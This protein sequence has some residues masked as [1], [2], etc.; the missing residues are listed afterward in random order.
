MVD[1]AWK[2]VTFLFYGVGETLTSVLLV[3]FIIAQSPDKMKGF[4]F[5]NNDSLS[6]HSFFV[7]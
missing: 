1:V 7:D 5:W 4:V 3:E 6:K 2:L